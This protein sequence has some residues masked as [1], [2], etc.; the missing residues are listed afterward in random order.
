MFAGECASVLEGDLIAG[1][2]MA[3]LTGVSLDT[4]K[5]HSGDLYFAIKGNRFDGHDFVERALD[6]G[7]GGVV[8]SEAAEPSHPG[9]RIKVADTS[10]ALLRLA[11]HHRRKWEGQL[12]CV[13][14]SVGKTTTKEILAELLQAQYRVH[15]SPGNFNNIYGLSLSLLGLEAGHERAVIEIGM[16]ASGEIEQLAS[17]AAPDLGL[18]TNVEAAH[19]EFFQS[20]EEIAEAKAEL[21]QAL[22]P[23]GLLVY[24]ADDARLAS[25]ADRYRGRKISYGLRESNDVGAES[26]VPEG[27]TGTRFRLRA[28]GRRQPV[29]LPLPGRH[30]VSNFLAAAAAAAAW[31]IELE[32]IAERA[33]GISPVA[34][35][36][37][38]SRFQEGFTL[39]DDTYNSNPR[40]VQRMIEQLDT[41]PGFQRKIL[42][43][44]EMLELG[45]KTEAFHQDCGRAV[46][47]GGIDLLL[48]IQGAARLFCESAV[49]A[50]MPAEWVHFFEDS[51]SAGTFLLEELQSGDL[52]VLKGSRG[53]HLETLVSRIH[54]RFNLETDQT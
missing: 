8:V 12:A 42:V 52:V 43:A 38:V 19:M 23:H 28:D 34:H 44:G 53:V 50:G 29:R 14:G 24:N 39:I 11:A 22:P 21:L 49:D 47:R 9:P 45:S 13:T 27:L 32:E 54:R 6:I 40:A 20:I 25:L 41:T 37:V 4:R 5:L 10:T 51:D 30:N 16:N 31:G 33:A 15:R 46:A 2:E 17:A 35:R 48:G 1:S 7:A 3:V 18:L 26:I 36:G